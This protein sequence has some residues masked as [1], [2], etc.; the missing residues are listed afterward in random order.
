[1]LALGMLHAGASL[2]RSC[3]AHAASHGIAG[4]GTLAPDAQDESSGGHHAQHGNHGLP[5]PSAP[6]DQC[7][8][9]PE[10]DCCV[11]V[12]SCVWDLRA[13][14]IVAEAPVTFHGTVDALS[15][16]RPNSRVTAP[17]PPPPRG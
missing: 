4:V 7:D 9:S 6:A 12:T 14:V 15:S 10:R 17:E 13:D 1:M 5:E 8:D 11:G 3:D 16:A 2:A